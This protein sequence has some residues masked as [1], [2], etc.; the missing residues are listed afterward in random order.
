MQEEQGSRLP[1]NTTK[2]MSCECPKVKEN[3]RG[4]G[5]RGEKESA[6]KT[7]WQRLARENVKKKKKKRVHES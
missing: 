1:R 5:F 2:K 3:K 7:P 6:L 4:S